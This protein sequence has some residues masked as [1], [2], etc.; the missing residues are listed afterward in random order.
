[1]MR[2]QFEKDF[3]AHVAPRN[4]SRT[5]VARALRIQSSARSALAET[6]LEE[7]GNRSQVSLRKYNDKSVC[8]LSR[9]QPSGGS[10]HAGGRRITTKQEKKDQEKNW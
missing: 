1:M 7:G 4:L 10:M 3:T 6:P 8:S 5:G 2:A 9:S